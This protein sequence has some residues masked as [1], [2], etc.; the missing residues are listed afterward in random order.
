VEIV[1][2]NPEQ[3]YTFLWNYEKKV[4][5][6]IPPISAKRPTTSH[7]NSLNIKMT[8]DNENQRL[9]YKKATEDMMNMCQY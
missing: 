8:Y 1:L 7:I 4:L 2:A 6:V 5:T 9:E 3:G